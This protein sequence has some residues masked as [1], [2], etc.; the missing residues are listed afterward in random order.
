MCLVIY[1][2]KKLA[3]DAFDILSK[4]FIFI[5]NNRTGFSAQSIIHSTYTI[6]PEKIMRTKTLSIQ[7]NTKSPSTAKDV[8]FG[9]ATQNKSTFIAKTT[10]SA[11]IIDFFIR[12]S[13]DN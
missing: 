4:H 10:C 6:G 9:Y 8:R 1:P 3:S 12:I 13:E 11:E 5:R 7:Q 2:T